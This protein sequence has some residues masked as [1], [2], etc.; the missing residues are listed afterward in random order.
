MIPVKVNQ[1]RRVCRMHRHP[2]PVGLPEIVN[3][4]FRQF[5]NE[6]F[7]GAQFVGFTCNDSVAK[8]FDFSLKMFASICQRKWCE[9]SLLRYPI[10]RTRIRKWEHWAT[11]EVDCVLCKL[12]F[13]FEQILVRRSLTIQGTSTTEN[14]ET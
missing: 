12:R 2:P 10:I 5:R 1:K 11:C 6:F 9:A 3:F 8:N 14:D 7:A 4:C 13:Q